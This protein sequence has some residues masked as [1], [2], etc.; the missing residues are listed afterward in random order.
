MFQL[1]KLSTMVTM[2]LVFLIIS[3]AFD[4]NSY[5]YLAR[6]EPVEQKTI[7][8]GKHPLRIAINPNTDMIYVTNYQSHSISVID[9]SRDKLVA[10]ISGFLYPTDIFVDEKSNKIYVNHKA[11]VEDQNQ[12]QYSA[13]PLVSIIDGSTNKV[14]GN[15]SNAIEI[16]GVN[17]SRGELYVI[18]ASNTNALV[19]IDESTNNKK[20]EVNLNY[21][22]SEITM[23][24]NTSK[25]YVA[26]NESNSISKIDASTFDL[27]SSTINSAGI[28][29]SMAVNPNTNRIYVASLNTSSMLSQP[30]VGAGLTLPSGFVSVV[31]G[32]T[33]QELANIPLVSPSALA[34][35]PDT[36]II[37][38]ANSFSG[39]ISILSGTN[40]TIISEDVKVG[41]SPQDIAVNLNTDKVYVSNSFSNSVTVISH[42]D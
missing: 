5:Y 33:D 26:N 22:P 30:N 28:P 6:G 3:L 18:Q 34:I 2:L 16:K 41:S 35:N 15:L 14:I 40:N 32:S 39:T 4:V 1:P 24:Q 31:D 8:V 11:R 37:Y 10:N 38:V 19:V 7:P 12:N 23:N 13:M 20:A 29:V 25:L 9:G 27:M 36:N 42:Q 17:S 21:Y